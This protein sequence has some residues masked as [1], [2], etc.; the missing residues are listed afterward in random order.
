VAVIIDK[1][2]FFKSQPC[3]E[4]I[5]ALQEKQAAYWENAFDENVIIGPDSWFQPS[6]KIRRDI[7]R[8]VSAAVEFYAYPVETFEGCSDFDEYREEDLSVFAR[9]ARRYIEL[10]YSPIPR[11]IGEDGREHFPMEWSKYCHEVASDALIEKWSQ[12]PNAM[13]ALCCGY[14]GL[15]VF[16][17]DTQEQEQHRAILGALPDFNIGRV[18]SKGFALLTLHHNEKPQKFFNIYTGPREASVKAVEIKGDGQNITVPPSIHFKTGKPYVW[19]NPHTGEHFDEL[20]PLLKLPMMTEHDL[21]ELNGDPVSGAPGAMT[22]WKTPPRPEP[23]RKRFN[24]HVD[25]NKKDKERRYKPYYENALRN[26]VIRLSALTEGRPSELFKQACAIGA[27]VHHRFISQREFEDG[28][29]DACRTNGLLARD[30]QHAI[31][32]TAHSALRR[33][34]NDELPDLPETGPG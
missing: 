22:P 28:L 12:I 18:G 26:T 30:G 24:G 15:T 27:G 17:V 2:I 14:G 1:P 20:P 29:L 21:R 19:I 5:E 9:Y 13:I 25:P 7:D 34:E 31:L 16:D 6:P 33:S 8:L 32:A 23:E 10:G 3:D 11:W 4:K